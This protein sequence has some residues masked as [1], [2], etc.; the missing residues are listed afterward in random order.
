MYF[1]S[2]QYFPIIQLPLPF[3]PSNTTINL[4]SR[5]IIF[6]AN[7]QLKMY[8]TKP[9]ILHT[10][11]RDTLCGWL[12]CHTD[13]EII[14][15]G[16]LTDSFALQLFHMLWLSVRGL[17]PMAQLT[18]EFGTPLH[19]LSNKKVLWGFEFSYWKVIFYLTTACWKQMLLNSAQ[20]PWGHTWWFSVN[21]ARQLECKNP[22]MWCRSVI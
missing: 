14:T 6:A 15:T 19:V 11:C 18:V 4:A 5:Y 17:I 9:P 20:G 13:S 12:T 8:N 21:W 10:E 22:A 7:F 1:F 3:S 2:K 16:H